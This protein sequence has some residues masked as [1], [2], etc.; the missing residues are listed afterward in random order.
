[1]KLSADKTSCRHRQ[2]ISN[3]VTP[4]IQ[5]SPQV[6]LYHASLHFPTYFLTV[7]P[8]NALWKTGCKDK[9]FWKHC[10]QCRSVGVGLQARNW[11][12]EVEI[13]WKVTGQ[14]AGSMGGME[15]WLRCLTARITT[16]STIPHLAWLAQPSP[17]HTVYGT[18]PLQL[19]LEGGSFR[20]HHWHRKCHWLL[21]TCQN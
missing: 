1:M 19:P 21:F 10:L 7:I 8:W 12:T 20:L 14:W 5:H 11:L 9:W 16:Q 6:L 18:L 4:I 2:G 15:T 13:Y 3:M 17:L